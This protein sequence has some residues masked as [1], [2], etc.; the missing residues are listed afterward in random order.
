MIDHR[1][2][3][4]PE[5]ERFLEWQVTT[6]VRRQGRFE[7]PARAGLR[8]YMGVAALAVV[9]MLV[10]AAGVTAS[11]RMQENAQTSRLVTEQRGEMQLAELQVELARKALDDAKTR[12]AVGASPLTAV[13]DAQTALTNAMARL[14]RTRL[15]I[16]EV[17]QSGKPVQDDITSPTVRG[18]DYVAERLQL[19]LTSAAAMANVEQQRLAEARKR[20]DV[21]LTSE[22]EVLEAQTDL[23]RALLEVTEMQARLELR[24]KFVAGDLSAES[25][26]Q[27]RLRLT[28]ES[29]LRVAE[30]G[31]N[32]AARRL[33]LVQKR[34][35]V[36]AAGEAELLR[37][38][39]E[40]VSKQND[41][42]NLKARLDALRRV[43]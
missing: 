39:L 12:V 21:G 16:A 3:P 2:E 29:Q 7:S 24:R 14:E 13:T 36:G 11:A 40:V 26:T 38:K 19:E 42:A 8:R 32:L 25:A 28:T 31:L 18:S 37:A 35:D 43:K 30:S 17:Q 4:S 15:D 9:S 20:H 5:F 10:G 27:E 23:Q 33:A 6:A 1:H 41:V 22:M 34:A